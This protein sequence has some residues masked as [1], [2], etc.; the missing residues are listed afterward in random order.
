MGFFEKVFNKVNAPSKEAVARVSG[1]RINAILNE[2]DVCG[3]RAD[4]VYIHKDTAMVWRRFM[5]ERL[6][7]EVYHTPMP[8]DINGVKVVLTEG[9]P[10]EIVFER[11]IDNKWVKKLFDVIE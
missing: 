10:R 5:S 9:D 2:S 1:E 11:K 8:G 4:F 7:R 3:G 6:G